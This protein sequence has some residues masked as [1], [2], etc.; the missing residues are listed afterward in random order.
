M[1]ESFEEQIA[2]QMMITSNQEKSFIDKLTAKED[3]MR[4]REIHK[5]MKLNRE[6]VMEMLQIITGNEAKFLNFDAFERWVFARYFLKISESFQI[7]DSIW[8]L[9][10][11]I[12]KETEDKEVLRIWEENIDWVNRTSKSFVNNFQWLTRSGMSI[13]G[14][15]FDKV[16][17]NRFELSYPGNMKSLE[18]KPGLLSGFFQKKGEGE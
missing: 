4:M 3:V 6:Q 10:E 13:G 9:Y 8:D 2:K 11:I 12:L 18:K 15:G 14:V 5:E 17:K 1:Q 7:D 16:L